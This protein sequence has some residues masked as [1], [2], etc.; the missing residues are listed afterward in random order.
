MLNR[1]SKTTCI[2]AALCLALAVPAVGAPAGSE[3]FPSEPGDNGGKDQ[4]S[5]P[6]GGGS[7]E[8]SEGSSGI[9]DSSSSSSSGSSGGVGEEPS[10]G[11]SG[12]ADKKD[13]AAKNP[14]AKENGAKLPGDASV[15]PIQ[16]GSS[17]DDGGDGVIDALLEPP[18]LAAIV[19]A[20]IA[21][22]A[23]LLRR[24]R[25]RPASQTPAG[26]SVP[27]ARRT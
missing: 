1:L 11:G 19:L 10:G 9:V 5:K 23:F 21:L 3:Y 4:G 26:P 27:A 16:A 7:G 24:R 2:T 8:S 22:A 6:S 15:A 14:E 18:V 12:D 20:A 13:V 17:E 25:K